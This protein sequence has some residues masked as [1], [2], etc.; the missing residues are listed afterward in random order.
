M[1]NKFTVDRARFLAA[2]A[3]IAGIASFQACT[4]EQEKV[5]PSSSAGTAGDA[6]AAEAGSNSTAGSSMNA[7]GQAGQASSPG[8]AAGDAMGGA[9]GTTEGGAAGNDVGGAA[10]GG[11]GAGGGGAGG[12]AGAAACDDSTPTPTCADVSAACT[13]YCNA[14]LANL[15]PAVADD[16]V[17]CLKLDATANCD[18]GYGCLSEATAKGCPEDVAADCA[19]AVETCTDTPGATDPSCAQLLSGFTDAA[20]VDLIACTAESCSTVYGCAEGFF[21]Q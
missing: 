20:R 2:A 4:V 14:A 15:K 21:F 16:A 3:A 18:A 6:G 9:A 5:K 19:A 10:P 1:S 8:G 7:G 11:A 13:P 12:A 17:T